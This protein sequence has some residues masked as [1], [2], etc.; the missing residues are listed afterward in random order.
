MMLTKTQSLSAKFVMYLA[1]SLM[2]VIGTINYWLY[3]DTKA[4]LLQSMDLSAQ[5]K[6]DTI[7]TLSGYYLSHFETELLQELGRSL[8]R[9]PEVIHVSFIDAN[10]KARYS[11]GNE[12]PQAGLSRAYYR[13]I[14]ARGEILGRVA[15]TLDARR[16][17]QET[18]SAM[19]RSLLM[20]LVSMLLLGGMLWLFFRIQILAEMERS[21]NEAERLR[22]EGDF[23]SAV[24]NTS[25]SYV[26]VI[27]QV[28]N[29]ILA[30][31]SCSQLVADIQA[32]T[33]PAW[34]YFD[35]VCNDRKLQDLLSDKDKSKQSDNIV[36]L[37]NTRSL[38][39]VKIPAG[40]D[41]IIEW[42]FSQLSDSRGHV[43]YLIGNG[44][45]ITE[46]HFKQEQLSYLAQHDSLTALPNRALFLKKIEEATQRHARLNEPFV[47]LYLDLDRF[48]P[49]NDTL[50][51]EAGDYVLKYVSTRMRAV[52]REVDMLARLGGDEFG[53][54]FSNCGTGKRDEVQAVAERLIASVSD[55]IE[56]GDQQLQL[57]VSIGIAFFP[58]DSHDPQQLIKYADHAM[59]AAKQAGRNTYRLF[60]C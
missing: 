49:I 14:V 53:V 3:E 19:A 55:P 4:H 30:N 26:L 32:A 15:L 58:T 22:E 47:L 38:C 16:L 60:S 37:C 5:F 28:G 1:A 13:D 57:G 54:I 27:D 2:L 23:I 9:E 59:Y 10:G 29:V 20:G 44:I 12:P 34:N 24:I 25:S 21:R 35:I 6:L 56:Y 48:K 18:H 45:D 7:A 43:K 41:L 42:C 52:L 40:E 51:H 46:Q 36:Q 31:K 50:G 8:S 17:H 11:Y 33:Q 39:R